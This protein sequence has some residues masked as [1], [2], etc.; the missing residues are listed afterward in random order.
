MEA[1]ERYSPLADLNLGEC[2]L[3]CCGVTQLL[4]VLSNLKNPLHSLSIAHN[5]LGRLVWHCAGR[6]L[7]FD[8]EPMFQ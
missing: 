3:S 2:D 4:D 5:E 8:A 6:N 7:T 1:S